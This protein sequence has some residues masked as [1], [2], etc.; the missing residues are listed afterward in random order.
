MLMSLVYIAAENML[1][2][3]AD[4]SQSTSFISMFCFPTVD[5]GDGGCEDAALGFFRFFPK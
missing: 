5:G 4:N 1:D 3:L 2:E